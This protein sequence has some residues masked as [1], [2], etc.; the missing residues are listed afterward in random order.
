MLDLHI[1]A[2][3]DSTWD[4]RVVDDEV[5]IGR[6]NRAALTIPDRSLSRLHVRLFKTEDG[7]WVEDLGSRNGTFVD[8]IRADGATRIN[9]GQT[10]SLG[11]SRVVLKGVGDGD[12]G[13]GEDILSGHTVFRSVEALLESSPISAISDDTGEPVVPVGIAAVERLRLL[14][15]VHRALGRSIELQELLDIILDS[16][17]DYLKPEDGA[18]FLIDEAGYKRVAGRSTKG[19]PDSLASTSL[20]REVVEGRQAALVLD[21]QDDERFNQAQSMI[22]SGL[23]SILAAPLLDGDQALGL[24]VLG[25]THGAR[26][27][28]EEDMEL[29]VSLASVAAMRISNVRLA[30]EA[31]ERRVLEKE[32]ALGRRIQMA[33]LPD[34]LPDLDGWELHAGNL[35]S[36]GVSGDIYKVFVREDGQTLVILVADVSGKGIAASLLTASLEALSAGPLEEGIP[37]DDCCRRVSRLLYDRTPPEKYATAFIAE[38][39]ISTGRV[40]YVNAGH[41]PGLVLRVGGEAQWLGACGVPLGLL[42]EADY[43]VGELEMAS[44]DVMML[45]TDGL[46]EATNRDEEEFGEVRLKGSALS[47]RLKPL[48]GMA[49]QIE[50]DLDHFTSGEPYGDDRTLVLV[51]RRAQGVDRRPGESA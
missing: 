27:F 19:E 16:V 25:S 1:T 46:T 26:V 10:L 5:V 50:G 39:E 31:A 45:Y 36:R 30:E 40:R 42:P 6:S 4:H 48:K 2:P 12:A 33:L 11:G 18:I 13:S 9:L 20:I 47:N 41:N 38:V 29:L 23:R 22:L 17:F 34:H 37:L 49:R 28:D 32:V 8:Q 51:R 44:R 35:P 15:D 24:I 43:S 21:A 14:N 7:W 3:D